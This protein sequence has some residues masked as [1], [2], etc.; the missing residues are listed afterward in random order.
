MNRIRLW[1]TM[2][3]ATLMAMLAQPA[4]AQIPVTDGAV[5]G[6]LTALNAL[7]GTMDA[8]LTASNGQLININRG[9]T[10]SEATLAQ[11]QRMFTTPTVINGRFAR[12]D[13]GARLNAIEQ[14]NDYLSSLRGAAASSPSAL[15]LLQQERL[16]MTDDE[17]KGLIT[18]NSAQ[19]VAER[20]RLTGVNYQGQAYDDMNVYGERYTVADTM[21]TQLSAIPDIKS[22]MVYQA[23]LTLQ[24]LKALNLL[25]QSISLN[26][27][28]VAESPF[29]MLK[30]FFRIKDDHEATA[31]ML[32][33]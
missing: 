14:M 5:V 31:K 1:C 4:M 21:E 8:T 22:A 9:V 16:E 33:A 23:G 25:G 17:A 18:G 10:A 29:Y 7:A 28:A 11:M 27:A 19:E 20:Q 12:L 6:E 32:A 30:E 24:V 3:A 26:T 13:G 2:L 15:R